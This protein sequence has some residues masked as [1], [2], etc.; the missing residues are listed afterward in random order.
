[1]EQNT[2]IDRF[3]HSSYELTDFRKTGERDINTLFSFLNNLHSLQDRVR[4]QFG[5]TISQHPEFKLLRIIR[6]Y[7]HHVGDV[8]EF[9]VFNT[10]NEFSLSH[11]EMIIIPL[12]VVAKAI[13]NA[14]KKPNGGKEIK[15]ISEFIDDFEYISER[16]AFFSERRFFIS[17][18]KQYYPGFDIYKCVYNITNII[19]DIC[20]DIPELS[21]KECII[22]L[23]ENYTS[24]N[25]IGKLNMY[26]HAGTVPFL[27][28]E[29]F[30][31]IKKP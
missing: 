14:K 8:D 4:E 7:H 9:R 16:D 15:K 10:R 31:I 19:A 25:N 30:I 13:I 27:T 6:N 20:R 17:E 22:S 26:C 29:G 24:T 23:D 1:M 28:T 5:K 21:V 2:F 3:F 11:S 12:F 18:D